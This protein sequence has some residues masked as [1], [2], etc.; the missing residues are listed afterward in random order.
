MKTFLGIYRIAVMATIACG[1][2][3][4]GGTDASASASTPLGKV[5]AAPTSQTTGA[6]LVLGAYGFLFMLRR[7]SL[8]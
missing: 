4:A 3:S 6:A 7:R 5:Q 8:R 1:L 2:I